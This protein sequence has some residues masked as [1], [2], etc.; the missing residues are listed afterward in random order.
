MSG[1]RVELYWCKREAVERVLKYR[2]VA[3]INVM[4]KLSM[5]VVRERIHEWVEESGV[6][7]DIQG[8]LI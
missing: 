6:L 4:C 1:R 8:G 2:P 5:I 3:I 7:S